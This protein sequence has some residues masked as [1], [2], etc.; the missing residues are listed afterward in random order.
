MS[1]D[2]PALATRVQE[3]SVPPEQRS[4]EPHARLESTLDFWT[5]PIS[6]PLATDEASAAHLEGRAERL[7]SWIV[8]FLATLAAS[9]SILGGAWA[10]G[11]GG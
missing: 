11:L 9:L 2:S 1:A 5:G 3:G 7:A 6:D 8:T 10:L 4:G